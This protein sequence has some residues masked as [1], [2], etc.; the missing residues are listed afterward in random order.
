MSISG[1]SQHPP[2]PNRRTGDELK[3]TPMLPVDAF[4]LVE[5]KGI[6]GSRFYGKK[7]QVTILATET[8]Q[9]YTEQLQTTILPGI[10]RSNIE[11]TGI[12]LMSPLLERFGED[13]DSKKVK[14]EMYAANIQL[15][16][17]TAVVRYYQLREPCW[18]MDVIAPGLQNLMWGRDALVGERLIPGSRHLNQGIICQVETSGRISRGDKV[19]FI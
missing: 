19:D 17:G 2:K 7:R 11:V 1:L 15:Q 6:V 18:E 4:E 10:L 9:H 8:I 12:D 5:G 13:Y 16:I 3:L 14:A